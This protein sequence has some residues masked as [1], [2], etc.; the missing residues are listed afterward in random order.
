MN[1][2]AL[3]DTDIQ[4]LIDMPKRVTNANARW[5]DNRG[6]RQKNYTVD[7]GD[8]LFRIYM[9]QNLFDQENFSCG[10]AVIKPNGEPLTLLRYNGSSH[11]HGDIKYACHIHKTT[12]HS[13]MIGAKPESFAKE[14]SEYSSL[15]GALSSMVRDANISGILQLKPDQPD[16]FTNR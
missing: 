3:T 8:H 10:L 11:P 4:E 2:D 16:M 5:K 6:S 9:R 13:I 1:F 14:T 7:G 15:D 12:E